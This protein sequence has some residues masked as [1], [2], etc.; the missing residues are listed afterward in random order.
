MMPDPR[1]QLTLEGAV[2][3]LTITREDKLNALDDKMVEALGALC[4]EIERNKI[5]RLVILTGAGQKAFSAGGDIE[6]W[7]AEPAQEFGRYWVREGHDAF[8]ALAR[9]RQP[10]IAVLNGHTL[11]GGFELAAV[12]DLRIAEAH[13]KIGQPETGLGVIPGWSGTQRAVRRF[14]AQLV[15]R[16]ALFGEVFSAQQA[17]ELGLVD[18][19]VPTGEGRAQAD[20]IA[21]RVLARGPIATEITKML[22]N[23]AE[24]EERERVLESLAGALAA[25]SEDLQEGV[26]AFKQ[27]RKP[28]FSGR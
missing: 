10:L 25:S 15:R 5:V 6:A 2:A 17:L 8:A 20:V 9:L 27:K 14:G 22:I 23:A 28:N 7:S 12:A 3:V 4:R 11:G 16:M 13:I 19:V 21:E 24:G 18:A 1:L 26:S